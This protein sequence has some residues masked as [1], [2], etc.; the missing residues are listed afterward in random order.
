MP[1]IWLTPYTISPILAEDLEAHSEVMRPMVKLTL[2]LFALA[3]LTLSLGG[4]SV[5]DFLSALQTRET[6]ARPVLPAA[7][8]CL[9]DNSPPD[10]SVSY[11]MPAELPM[12]PNAQEVRTETITISE[13]RVMRRGYPLTSV[14]TYKTADKSDVVLQFYKDWAGK[15]HWVQDSFGSQMV[16][17]HDFYW[18]SSAALAEQWLGKPCPPPISCC[19]PMNLLS[20]TVK[21]VNGRTEVEIQDGYIPG[22]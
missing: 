13:H 9:Y 18:D 12:Y 3:L 2:R 21:E 4:C 14:T 22:M 20:V 1:P 15:T 7:T 10:T 16:T 5:S 19:L 6:A 17:E 8:P 11:L